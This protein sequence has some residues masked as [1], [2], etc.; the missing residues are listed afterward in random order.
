MKRKFPFGDDTVTAVMSPWN[1]SEWRLEDSQLTWVTFISSEHKKA[2]LNTNS[3]SKLP[4]NKTELVL[5]LHLNASGG[6][7]AE[8]GPEGVE[9]I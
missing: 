1:K 4:F 3:K 7:L 9:N 2:S 8:I 5:C 6:V